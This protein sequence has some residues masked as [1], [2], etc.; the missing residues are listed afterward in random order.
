MGVILDSKITWALVIDKRAS[1]AISRTP[2]FYPLISQNSKLKTNI[3]LSLC[4]TCIRP[5]ITY[6]YQIW[7]AAA[8]THINKIQRMQNKF[9]RV[10]LKLYVTPIKKLHA[11][12]NIPT[13][14]EYIQNSLTT[15]YHPSHYNPLISN[16]GKHNQDHKQAPQVF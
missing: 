15:A 3:K 11:T 10:I 2:Q 6:G 13:I 14:Q 1:L 4:K 12:A 8:K 16:T 9:L 5:I 7:V